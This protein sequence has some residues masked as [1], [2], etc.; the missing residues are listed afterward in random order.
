MSQSPDADDDPPN[1]Y[2]PDPRQ[3]EDKSWL[4]EQYWGRILSIDEVA[5]QTDVS[6]QTIV[7]RMDKLGIPRRP[8]TDGYDDP[9]DVALHYSSTYAECD[10]SASEDV[11][12]SSRCDSSSR[13][14]QPPFQVVKSFVIADGGRSLTWSD[15]RTANDD[16]VG[17]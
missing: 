3:W 6:G 14:K 17:P 1:K 15:V 9:H 4:Y 8:S 12:S 10:V 16:H 11:Q 13:L 5:A 2:V 7:R